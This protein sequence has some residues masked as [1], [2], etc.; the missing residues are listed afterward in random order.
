MPKI[1]KDNVPPTNFLVVRL[2]SEC[3]KKD[4]DACVASPMPMPF[5][6]LNTA[7]GFLSGLIQSIIDGEN[8]DET[9]NAQDNTSTLKDD[10]G[11]VHNY[12]YGIIRVS[13]DVVYNYGDDEVIATKF[14]DIVQG[15]FDSGN[16]SK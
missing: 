6:T 1:T 12:S 14:D 16:D 5:K 10:D 13:A 15:L 7:K 4:E 9:W 11:E 8:D 3:M 2:C